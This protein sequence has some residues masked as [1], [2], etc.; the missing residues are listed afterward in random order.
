GCS[1]SHHH[2]PHRRPSSMS[3]MVVSFLLL[4]LVQVTFAEL[5]Q[6]FEALD[7]LLRSDVLS[8]PRDVY[9]GGELGIFATFKAWPDR[10]NAGLC[11]ERNNLPLFVYSQECAEL[12]HGLD[13]PGLLI[14]LFDES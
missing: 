5:L 6:F 1:G 11:D 14:L 2:W 13:E 3:C 4:W 7:I 10:V 9:G 12:F 8:P